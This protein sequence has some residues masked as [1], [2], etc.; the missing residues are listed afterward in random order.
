MK[1]EFKTTNK[2]NV[3][4]KLTRKVDAIISVLLSLAVINIAV[5]CSY[6]TAKNVSTTKETIVSEIETFNETKKYVIIH[7]NNNSWHMDGMVINEDEQNISGTIEPINLEHQYKKSRDSKRVHRY[8]QKVTKPLDEIHFYLRTATTFQYNENVEISLSDIESISVNDKNTG[9]S[10]ANIALT[11][12]GTIFVAALLYAALKSS[13]PFVYIK[14]GKEYD[15][16]GELYPGII[17][18]NMQSDDYLPLPNFSATNNEY[19]LK[20][21]NQ[22]KEIQNTDQLQLLL[23]NHHKNIEVLL[24][25]KGEVQTFNK[26]ESPIEVV[27]DNGTHNKT[28]ALK[29]DN[30]FYSFNTSI[31]TSNSTRSIEFMFDKP[32]MEQKAKLYLTAKNSVWLDYIF[33]KFNE[34][35]GMYYSTFQK[36]QQYLPAEEMKKWANAQNIPLSIHLKTKHGWQLVDQIKTVGPMAMR[37]IAILIDLKDV[38]GDMVQIKLETGFMF[39]EVDYVGMDFSENIDLSINHIYPSEAI[40]QNGK[41]VTTLLLER[42][43]IYFTQPNIGDEV[44]VKFPVKDYNLELAQTVFLKN[45]GYYNYKRDY[46]GVP[47]FEKLQAFREDNTFTRFSE[48]SYFDFVNFNLR[49]FAYHE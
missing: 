15:F 43:G 9:R 48:T 7:S 23:V 37:D 42:D 27:L 17:T 2:V 49:T 44:V 19:I 40:D 1:L 16:I 6:Y 47:D 4:L 36:E 10:I 38:N 32:Q 21:T 14:N 13:C 31:S 30:D 24:D 39:W 12:V 33:G 25:K 29:K 46:K 45:R 5:S 41:N 28:S 18:A 34:Q 22:L 26:V 8:K 35:F 3:L 20:V 11:T